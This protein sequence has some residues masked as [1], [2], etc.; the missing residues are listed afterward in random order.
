MK[1]FIILLITG[2]VQF[3]VYSADNRSLVQDNKKTFHRDR[4]VGNII[5]DALETYHY[6]QIKIDNKFSKK[7]FKQFLEGIDHS[8]QFLLKSDVDKLR[9]YEFKID[10]QIVSGN[11]KLMATAMEILKKRIT[12]IQNYREAIFKKP[13]NF[14][15]REYL[16]F[17][18][19]KKKYAKTTAVLKNYW[20]KIFKYAVIS[21]YLSLLEQQKDEIK[22]NKKPKKKKTAKKVNKRDDPLLGLSKK[23]LRA[24]AKKIY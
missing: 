14:N 23:Q 4:L 19:E 13:F 16:E 3:D 12:M 9:K 10:D 20:R 15:K 18:S 5:K 6:R 22:E 21:H 11:F 17:K 2:L 8:K 7:A 24:K 1:V